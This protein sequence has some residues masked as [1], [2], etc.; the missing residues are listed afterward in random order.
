MAYN[1]W[2]NNSGGFGGGGSSGGSP[3]TGPT[4]TEYEQYAKDAPSDVRRQQMLEEAAAARAREN[5]YYSGAQAGG[6]TVDPKTGQPVNVIENPLEPQTMGAPVQDPNAINYET[7]RRGIDDAPWNNV[8][9]PSAYQYGGKI[10]FAEQEQ[11]YYGQ[12]ARLA[13]ARLAPTINDT[14]YGRQLGQDRAT[15]LGARGNQEYG[16]GQLQG[17]I[18]G[19]GP[20]VA[21]Q[22]QNI[23][24]AQAMQQQ[25][26]IAANAR[27]G[28]ANIA[29]AQQQAA[30]NAA[31]L[32]GNAVQQ[33][34]MLR[35]QEQT[36]AINAYGGQASALRGADQQ[37]AQQAGQLAQQQANINMQNR[38]VNDTRNLAYE[39]ARK[40][41]VQTQGQYRQAGEA[42][43]AGVYASNADRNQ[44]K[45]MADDARTDKWISSGLA[46]AG[47]I[48]AVASDERAK[49][50]IKDGS[51]QVQDTMRGLSA[52]EFGYKDP[53]R[54]GEGRKLGVSAQDME[55]TGL[56]SQLIRH[57]ADGTKMIDGAG[58]VSLALA[59]GAENQRRL[60][61]LD[62]KLG[63]GKK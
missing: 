2:G 22:Q 13:D 4:S 52:I 39:N 43:N 58:G 54:H 23:G 49:T 36:N 46:A 10:G 57:D 40:E 30:Q 1:P 62:A 37:R 3:F 63:K 21:Q 61:E 41:V 60:D 56:G 53:Q 55:A 42:A 35:A 51:G 28:G 44:Q 5:Q 16:L 50:G 7:Y 38:Q 31:G 26:S 45:D 9:Q 59:A 14:Y 18:E 25:A 12:K 34:A 19:R 11:D 48:A 6:A 27:G 20:S 15:E 8:V 47:T 29:F 32:S 33:S 24:L 17:I